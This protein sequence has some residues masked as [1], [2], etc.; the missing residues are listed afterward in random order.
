MACSLCGV[1]GLGRPCSAHAGTRSQTYEDQR[2]KQVRA[3]SIT[4]E[5]VLDKLYSH[6]IARKPLRTEFRNRI[7]MAHWKNEI[8]ENTK[9]PR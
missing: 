9:K 4:S 7:A 1:S 8:I 3:A 6:S 5:D 2:S